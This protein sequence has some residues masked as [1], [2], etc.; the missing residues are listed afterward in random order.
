[1]LTD[2]A[3]VLS[4]AACGNTNNQESTESKESVEND[5]KDATADDSADDA[6]VG[7]AEQAADGSDR[8]NRAVVSMQNRKLVCKGFQNVKKGQ[9]MLLKFRPEECIL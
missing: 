2:A 3:M 5:T 6:E 4:L 8:E 9:K 1:M 7:S